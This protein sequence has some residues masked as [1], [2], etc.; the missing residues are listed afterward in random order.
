[1]EI[2][3]GKKY[4]VSIADQE[5][6]GSGVTKIEN[7]V[8]FVENGLPGD[9]GTAEIT[10]VKKNFARGKMTSFETYSEQRQQA[11]C[12]YYDKCGGCD[13][14]H[15]NYNYQLLF[16]E[17]KVKTAMERIGGFKDIKINKIISDEQFNYRNKISLKVKGSIVGLYEHDTNNI[18]DI[19]NCMICNK[20][21]ND[22]LKAVREFVNQYPDNVF[23]GITI[24]YAD[25]IMIRVHS[26]DN[27][28]SAELV[29]NLTQGIPNLKSL[30]L[31]GK[32]IYG[33][34]YIEERIGDLRFNLSATSFYQVNNNVMIKLYDKVLEETSKIN[35]ETILDLYC[36]IGTITSLLAKQANKVIGIEFSEVAVEDAI[37]N[38]NLNNINNVTIKLGKVEDTIKSLEKETIDTIVMDPPRTGIEKEVIDTLI[39]LNP[40]QIIYVSCNPVTLARDTKILCSFNYEIVDITPFDMFPQTNHVECVAKLVRKIA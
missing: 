3:F 22:A 27:N 19:D 26:K 39:K 38:L 21:I 4:N 8:T 9:V 2:E 23:E 29:L 25:G 37:E 18:V 7:I 28:L 24:R 10:E 16:K 30:Y 32:V 40:K 14:Q 34:S 5:N 36:G 20:N 6:E 13:L 33:V 11:P 31:N 1:M 15:Q 12:P 17:H 35:N